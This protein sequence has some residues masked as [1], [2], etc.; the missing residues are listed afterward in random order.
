[1]REKEECCFGK[2]YIAF[3]VSQLRGS[4][5]FKT[6]A[7]AGI[8][9]AFDICICVV[10]SLQS[11]QQRVAQKFPMPSVNT[12]YFHCNPREVNFP[13]INFFPFFRRNIQ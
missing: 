2:K 11:V 4:R 8:S 3:P 10:D 13:Q 6:K 5:H 9:L 1:M 12:V 7:L